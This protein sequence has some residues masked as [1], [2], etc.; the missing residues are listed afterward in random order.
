MQEHLRS[1][2]NFR[3]KKFALVLAMINFVCI[4]SNISARTAENFN[5]R[6]KQIASKKISPASKKELFLYRQIAINFFCRSRLGKIEF[7]KALG[8]SSI[9]FADIISS[10]HNGFVDEFPDKKLTLKQLSLSAEIQVLEGA[11]K[12]CPEHVPDDAK[13]KFKEFVENEKKS[14]KSTR[15]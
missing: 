7:P 3:P 12:Y 14:N 11:I 9:T 6:D 13:K 4:G 2:F 1:F 8:I 15:K 10:K 5:I